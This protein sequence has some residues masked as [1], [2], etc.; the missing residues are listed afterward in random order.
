MKNVVQSLWVGDEISN[1]ERLCLQSFIKN[2]YDFHLFTYGEIKELPKG[3]K[4]CDANSII[5]KSEVFTFYGGS[6]AGFADWFR[7][8]LLYKKGGLWVDMDVVCLKPF[9][10][11][12]DFVFGWQDCDFVNIA[13]LK[14]PKAHP[15]ASV[16]A[17]RCKDPNKILPGDSFKI[18]VK[19][20]KRKY[21]QGNRRNNV[22]WGES[23]GPKGFTSLLKEM[24]LLHFAKPFTCFYPV[25]P[26]CWKSFFDDT[27]KGNMDFFAGSYAV[28]LWNEA[29]RRNKK[30]DKNGIFSEDSVFETLKRK[31]LS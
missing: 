6:Y 22:K 7:Y 15:L 26:K 14:F 11:D 18:K 10:F 25:Q 5:P 16:L 24:N 30:F 12:D 3:V 29:I 17:E 23:G 27:F 28:H 4:I 21:L 20:L 2:G 1:V 31:Y 8:E 19:K 13:V 9:D